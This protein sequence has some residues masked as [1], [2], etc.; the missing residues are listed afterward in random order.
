MWVGVREPTSRVRMQQAAGQN[1]APVPQNHDAQWCAHNYEMLPV[2]FIPV[3]DWQQGGVN[4][5][6]RPIAAASAGA[7]ARNSDPAANLPART[8][9]ARPRVLHDCSASGSARRQRKESV[10]FTRLRSGRQSARSPR[11]VSALEQFPEI[12]CEP[13][14]ACGGFPGELARRCDE[15]ADRRGKTNSTE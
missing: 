2:K 13:G 4:V 3:E 1:A 15:S 7:M 6:L 8:R 9:D 10:R 14:G 11:T 12:L 5:M